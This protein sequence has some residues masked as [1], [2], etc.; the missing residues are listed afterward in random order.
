V[1]V[2]GT[3]GFA[4][5]TGACAIRTSERRTATPAE[6]HMVELEGEASRYWPRWRGPTGQGLAADGAYP[7]TWSDTQNVHWKVELPGRGNSSP[8]V[9]KD[10]LFLTTAHDAGR[11]R[12]ILC[13]QRDDGRLLWEAFAPETEP[14]RAQKKNGY[15]SATPCTDGERVYAYFGNHGLLCVAFD[16]RQV[17]HHSFGDLDAYHGTACSPLLYRDRVIV[18]QDHRSPS[19]SF[20][21][22]LDKRTGQVLWRTPRRE[23]VGWGSPVAVRVGDHDEIVVSGQQRVCAYDPQTGQELWTCDGNLF[24]VTPTPVVGHGLVF[25]CSGR[26]G[27]TLAIQPGGTGDVTR[28][29]VAWQAGTGSPFI[30]S[31]LVYGDHL[32]MVNDVASVARCYEARTGKLLWQERLGRAV[33]HGFSASPVAAGGKIF[34]TNEAGETYVLA[35]GPEFR[36]LHVNKLNAPTLASPALVDGRWYFRTDR[37]LLCIGKTGG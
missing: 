37:H 28:T 2:L 30:P 31:P 36:L 32:Y 16:G 8:I 7:D 10:R 17:W 25:C 18:Y 12:S 19:G 24:E 26:T 15:A 1:L 33:K 23:N 27:P 13:L 9:W 34:F 35:A 29:Q 21:T 5:L 4:L 11:R 22:A 6:I 20:V 3:A 14:E